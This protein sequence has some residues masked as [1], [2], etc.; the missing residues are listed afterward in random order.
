[1]YLALTPSDHLA[2]DAFCL[3]S[4]LFALPVRPLLRGPKIFFYRGPNPLS[5]ALP[6]GRFCGH[7]C[8]F[9]TVVPLV[10]SLGKM[11]TLVSQRFESLV[12]VNSQ[13]GFL[14]SNNRYRELSGHPFCF[15]LYSDMYYFSCG[16]VRS[17]IILQL[18]Y[19]VFAIL[20]IS[21]AYW[22]IFP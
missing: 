22:L 6:D 10:S 14:P 1:M 8:W 19:S 13:S 17:I 11:L 9:L 2:Y 5:E 21:T 3:V 20:P 16:L 7:S 4:F 12:T 15:L 18:L